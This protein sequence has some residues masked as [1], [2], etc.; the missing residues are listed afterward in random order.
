MKFTISK[1]EVSQT[2]PEFLRRAGYFLITDRLTDQQSFVKR[3]SASSFYPRFHLYIEEKT[4][5]YQLNLHLDQKRPSYS[6]AKAHNADYDEPQVAEE[7]AR[8][9][10]FIK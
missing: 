1:T 8:I 2:M 3:L 4:D 6:G 9:L 10:N 5:Q 7:K